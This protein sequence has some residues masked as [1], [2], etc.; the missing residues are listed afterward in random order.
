MTPTP[1]LGKNETVKNGKRVITITKPAS[2]TEI[3]EGLLSRVAALENEVT[4]LKV[5]VK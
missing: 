4:A 2:T 3:V 1:K 5:K